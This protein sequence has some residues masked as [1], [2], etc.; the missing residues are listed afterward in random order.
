MAT[1]PLLPE[2]KGL[3][4]EYAIPSFRIRD[5]NLLVHCGEVHIECKIKSGLWYARWAPQ[6]F[7]QSFIIRPLLLQHET[8]NPEELKVAI[9][10]IVEDDLSG[11]IDDEII[12]CSKE[13]PLFAIDLASDNK[14]NKKY[15]NIRTLIPMIC[16]NSDASVLALFVVYYDN[17]IAELVRK[18][19][20]LI[21]EERAIKTIDRLRVG[22]N[23]TKGAL[24]NVTYENLQDLF[25]PEE[26]KSIGITS[27]GRVVNEL[28]FKY[29]KT[30]IDGMQF[31]F[32]RFQ[33]A[34]TNDLFYY[35]TSGGVQKARDENEEYRKIYEN[36]VL[37][38]TFPNGKL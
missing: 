10:S 5:G 37:A 17:I 1:P 35:F 33:R 27:P 24:Y 7:D 30:I 31:F 2:L 20:R 3:I 13:Q 23:Y 29:E 36:E 16:I 19:L 28:L 9:P 12:F 32:H 34:H 8:A 14:V 4:K 15:S 25:T 18:I 38:K 6:V 11:A 26:L 21:I 22:W